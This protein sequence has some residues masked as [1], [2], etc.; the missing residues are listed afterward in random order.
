MPAIAALFT[1]RWYMDRLYRWLVDHA[2][3]RGISRLC[4][5]NDH[6]VIDGGIDGLGKGITVAG[7]RVSLLH[8]G[9]IQYR[10]LVMFGVMVLLALYF[11]L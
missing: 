8:T 11:F 4:A 3:D 2:L 5:E 7:Q 10:L 9:M 1:E 6:R